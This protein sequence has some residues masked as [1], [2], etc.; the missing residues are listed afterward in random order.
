MAHILKASIIENRK[1][2]NQYFKMTFSSG[3][4]AQEARPG[5][6]VH[7]QCFNG[8][9]PFL[10][11]PF[12]IHQLPSPDEVQI[13][14][15]VVGRGTELLSQKREGELIDVMGPLGHGFSLSASKSHLLVAGGMGV[16]PMVYLA[17]CLR[18]EGRDS[19][20]IILGA[21]QKE[22]IL[23]LEEFEALPARIFTVTEDGSLGRRG[24]ATD[25]IKEVA[26]GCPHPLSLYA[27]GPWAML[28]QTSAIA[29]EESYSVQ[30]ALEER[31]ACGVGACLC[32][33]CP[34]YT[35]EGTTTYQRVCKDGPVFDGS[36][37]AWE[38]MKEA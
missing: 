27:C 21:R 11:R 10:R 3:P 32:C 37:V 1:I 7:L 4:I 25:L 22:E 14:Y 16:A 5:Q 35:P 34:V 29:M 26:E 6:F 9:E 33:P 20:S 19:L 30:V 15:K 36:K 8:L 12:S 23:C 17:Q 2:K 38:R 24:M 18:R 31:M 28:A 13:L